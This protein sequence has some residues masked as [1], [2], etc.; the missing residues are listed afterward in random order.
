[1]QK[2]FVERL[3]TNLQ[4]DNNPPPAALA[5]FGISSSIEW[6]YKYMPEY[7][8]PDAETPM[9][10]KLVMEKMK[11]KRLW[12]G[13]ESD[14]DDPRGQSEDLGDD[15]MKASAYGIKNLQRIILKL[16]EWTKEANK[17][18]SSLNELYTQLL[19]QYT[20]YMGHVS[21]NIG[22]VQTTPRMQEEGGVIVAFTPKAKQKEAMQFLQEQLFKT[23]SWLV[24]S[25]I[26]ELT[27][28]NA[29]STILGVQTNILSRLLG[30]NTFN[31]LFRYEANA[32]A[33]YSANDMI[34]DL[35]KGIWSELASRKAIDIYRRNLQKAFVERLITNLQTDNNPP[36]AALAVFGISSSNYSKTTDAIS[37]V[38]MQLRTLQSEIRNAL[39]AYKD[40]ASR[41]H[42]QDVNDRIT[43]ALD[44]KK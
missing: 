18:Y 12:F 17:D 20:R 34:T 43:E 33:A 44:T 14:Q 41:A 27:G 10:N 11:D 29:L 39:P 13:T 22:G 19:G 26:A 6:G 23:P 30:N 42:L 28:T 25:N 40:A 24:Q 37:I 3:I 9:L 4:T 21:K 2:A 5:V 1:L 15:A 36:P 31:K 38:K 32:T 8:T 7:R 35:R 16:P